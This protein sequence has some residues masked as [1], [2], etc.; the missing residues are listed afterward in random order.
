MVIIHLFPKPSAT[1][2]DESGVL[3]VDY[4]S[5]S[6][7]YV[8]SGNRQFPLTSRTIKSIVKRLDSTTGFLG[9]LEEMTEEEEPG[10]Y[11]G[12]PTRG[13]EK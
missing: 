7:Q 9:T 11:E 2:R 10:E 4:C 5:F 8:A 13:P 3:Q 6:G 12:V 1:F